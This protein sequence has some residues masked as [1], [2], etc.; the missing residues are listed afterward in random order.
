MHTHTQ[1]THNHAH[2]HTPPQIPLLLRDPHLD[3][4]TLGAELL[5]AFTAVQS[6]S[7]TNLAAIQAIT[8]LVGP[9]AAPGLWGHVE[10]G[11]RGRRGRAVAARARLRRLR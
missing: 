10:G 11:A 9:P 4:R 6:E 5:T 7:D 1:S 8:P 2:T 3:M